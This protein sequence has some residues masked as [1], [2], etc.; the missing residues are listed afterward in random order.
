MTRTLHNHQRR[1][2]WPPRHEPIEPDNAANAVLDRIEADVRHLLA[3]GAEAPLRARL[4]RLL[5]NRFESE[6]SL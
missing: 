3:I 6:A 1:L 4:Q 2:S 5:P